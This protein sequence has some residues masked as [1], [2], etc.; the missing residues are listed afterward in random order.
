MALCPRCQTDLEF[1]RIGLHESWKC[2]GCDGLLL[3]KLDP[4]LE[5]SEQELVE[6]P[7]SESL[8]ADHPQVDTSE[9]IHCPLCQAAMN[10]YVYCMD[11]G[12]VIDS[13]PAGHGTWLDDGELA[14][15]YDYLHGINPPLPG[16]TGDLNVTREEKV[17]AVIRTFP[18]PSQEKG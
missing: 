4:Y 17:T 8:F 2:P 1:V 9:A 16:V 11:S 13:C 7:L 14:K 3:K 5:M 6:T 10:R 18:Q 15:I 12:V